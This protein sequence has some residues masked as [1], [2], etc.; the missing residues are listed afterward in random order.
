MAK[1]MRF[2]YKENAMRYEN[3]ENTVQRQQDKKN[4]C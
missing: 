3:H 2:F 1:I 4:L